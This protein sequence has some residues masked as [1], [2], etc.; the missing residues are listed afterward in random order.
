MT[1]P[2]EDLIDGP[3]TDP[4]QRLREPDKPSA[5]TLFT[6]FTCW[7]DV[8]S[9]REVGWNILIDSNPQSDLWCSLEYSHHIHSFGQRRTGSWLS[10]VLFGFEF[11]VTVAF[12]LLSWRHLIFSNIIDLTALTPFDKNWTELWH[13]MFFIYIYSKYFTCYFVV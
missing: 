11:L 7:H 2:C 10:L 1:D 8:S 3:S 12:V 4:Q 5:Q 13:I 9:S 6:S